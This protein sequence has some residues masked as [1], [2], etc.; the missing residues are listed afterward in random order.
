MTLPMSL[1][2]IPLVEVKLGGAT[3]LWRPPVLDSA[4]ATPGLTSFAGGNRGMGCHA[5]GSR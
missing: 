2:P 3:I 4:G 5:A 1:A